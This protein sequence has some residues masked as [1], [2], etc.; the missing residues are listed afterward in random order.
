MLTQ[1]EVVHNT[2]SIMHAFPFCICLCESNN[3]ECSKSSKTLSV[4]PGETVQVP[5]VTAGQRNGVLPAAV[6]SR[7]DRGN[8]LRFQYV[9]QTIEMCTT[10]SYCVFT[11]NVT[12]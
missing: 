1:N 12:L 8:L 10:L 9:Q 3:P 6:M 11:G 4:Y 7:A 2:T 5:M